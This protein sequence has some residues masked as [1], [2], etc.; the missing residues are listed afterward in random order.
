[1][2]KETLISIFRIQIFQGKWAYLPEHTQRTYCSVAVFHQRVFAEVEQRFVKFTLIRHSLHFYTK[3]LTMLGP[4]LLHRRARY[5]LPSTRGYLCGPFPRRL[6]QF[7]ESLRMISG[8][9][10]QYIEDPLVVYETRRICILQSEL[11]NSLK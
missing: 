5:H 1:M 2:N 10:T 3:F 9:V 8:Q 4:V 11:H 7:M 6:P